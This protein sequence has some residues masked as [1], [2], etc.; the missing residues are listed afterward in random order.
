MLC[1]HRFVS[2]SL[3]TLIPFIQVQF[4]HPVFGF[5]LYFRI[6]FIRLKLQF[7]FWVR[8]TYD[9]LNRVTRITQSGTGVQGKR[10]DLSYDAANQM[11]GLSRYEDLAGTVSVANTS[12]TYDT[13][14]RLT[15]L[16]HQQGASTLAS[17]GLVYD[18]VNRITRSSGT[19]GVQDYTF[20]N[21]LTGVDHSTQAN[22]AYSYDANGN[23]TNAGYGTGVDNRL[24]TDG[25]Y[26]YAYDDEGNRTRRVEISSGK[27]TEYAWDYRNRLTGVLFKDAGGVVT[28]S[29]EYSYDVYNRRIAKVVDLDGV[30]SAL[31]TTEQYVYDGGQ[32]GLVFDGS[33]NQ[34]HRYLYGAG[35]DQILAD[36]TGGNV[37]WAVTDQQGSVSDVVDN[38]GVVLNH[39]VY[40][41]FGKVQSQSNPSVESRYG[42]T[43]RETDSET[44]LDYYRARYYDAVV[45]KFISEDPI[46]FAAGDGN[47]TRYV[48][49][50]P[51]NFT[52]PS[53][54]ICGVDD[55]IEL[56]I[57]GIVL[58][59][60]GAVGTANQVSNYFPDP[61]NRSPQEPPPLLPFPLPHNPLERGDHRPETY[62]GTPCA[63]PPGV[64]PTDL[65]P[66]N[67]PQLFPGN[68]APPFDHHIPVF[69]SD[70]G[71][72]GSSAVD[73][74]LPDRPYSHLKDPST[75]GPG[76][77]FTPSQKRKI[78]EENR[79]MN[80][81]VVKSDESGT[82]TT[83][84]QKSQKGVTPDPN[85]Y[86]IDHI[87]PKNPSDPSATP[88]TNSYSNARV[89]T[90]AENRAKSNK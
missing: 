62:G 86:Q 52:D 79:R 36:E 61:R 23:R 77:D 67:F 66:Y 10:V 88:G 58:T 16:T 33:G 34:T 25:V 22:E 47:L 4:Q 28:K 63:I 56:Y 21:Q 43:G 49:N 64:P 48:G 57:L 90:R 54:K 69:N 35:V 12:Y 80:G 65:T 82:V 18:A 72:S 85:E 15:N 51:T 26:N 37:R 2:Q 14:G 44:G 73:G 30:G 78:I 81:D 42:F 50:S 75:V 55:L 7:L 31:A 32:I 71:E 39:V 13:V 29:I 38:N 11:T 87:D 53:G 83:K 70:T 27:V 9:V 45:G 24:L 5:T 6:S 60:I 20:T 3:Y 17:Y 74:S 8:F 89:L 41:S 68:V 40:D 19:D 59:Y 84:P 76:K 46:R 1:T